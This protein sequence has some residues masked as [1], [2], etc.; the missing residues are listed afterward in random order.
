M[1]NS[2]FQ[3]VEIISIPEDKEIQT[4]ALPEI[5][6]I[7]NKEEQKIQDYI[8]LEHRTQLI[9]HRGFRDIKAQMTDV[10]GYHEG[11]LS[12]SLDVISCYLK[13]QK[14]LYLEAKAYCEFYL[15]RLMMPAIF[16]SSVASIISGVYNDNS[17]AAKIVSG[18]TALNA[19][20][21]SLINYFKL[22]A[23]AEAHKMTAYSFDQLISECEFTSGKILMCNDLQRENTNTNNNSNTANNDKDDKPEKYDLK[24]IQDYITDIEKKVKEIKEKNQFIIP[25]TIRNRYPFIYNSN[26]FTDIKILQIDEM[27]LCNELKVISNYEID[28]QNKIIKGERTPLNY[29]NLQNYYLKKNAKIEEIINHRKKI[30]ERDDDIHKE[31]K[32]EK[33]KKSGWIFY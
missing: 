26:I 1:S 24:Y 22:D 2:N 13:G 20:I 16:I 19:F 8:P 7:A 5:K 11:N 21:L 30:L 27:I 9:S 4:L 29:A 6:Q 15:Y 23:K 10:F 33:Y 14:I 32:N 28:Y 12:T 31:I 18:A 17:T 25:E 3:V